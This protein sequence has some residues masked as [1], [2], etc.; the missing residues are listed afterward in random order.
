MA[1][2]TASRFD[3]NRF[4]YQSV[5][6]SIFQ[7]AA[8]WQTFEVNI[9]SASHA[10]FMPVSIQSTFSILSIFDFISTPFLPLP[11]LSKAHRTA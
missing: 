5:S 11:P 4:I 3:E 10:T 8:G 1:R 7:K 6:V 2:L 9:D